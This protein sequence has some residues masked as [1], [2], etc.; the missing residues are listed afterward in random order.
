[1]SK[2]GKYGFNHRE[3]M[4]L[5]H[6]ILDRLREECKEHGFEKAS[7]LAF[8]AKRKIMLL[9]VTLTDDEVAILDGEVESALR[10][11]EGLEF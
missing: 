1:M 11:G 2:R 5:M 7:D 10:E 6:D 8:Q 4:G 9:Q 3:T